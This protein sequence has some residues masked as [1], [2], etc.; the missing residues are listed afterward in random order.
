M[1]T[2]IRANGVI[3][4]PQPGS[5]LLPSLGISGAIGRWHAKA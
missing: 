1:T 4:N 3:T 2:I 5:L